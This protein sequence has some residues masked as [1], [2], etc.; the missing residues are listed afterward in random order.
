MR[1]FIVT[2]TFPPQIGGM[3]NVMF[4][5]AEKL[6]M[7][8]FSV[9]VLPKNELGFDAGFSVIHKQLPKFLRNGF[10]Y[11]Y[12]LKHLNDDDIVICD[13]WKSVVAVPPHKG[14]LVVLA[15]GQEYLKSGRRARRVQKALNRA[16]HLAVISHYTFG[17]VSKGWSIDHLKT[18]IIPPT[19]MLPDNA[20]KTAKRNNTPLQLVSICRLEARKGLLQSL[21]A[22][23]A[24]GDQLPDWRWQIG[25]GGAQHQELGEAIAQFGLD[26]KVTLLGRVDDA[27]KDAM[28]EAADLF[29]MPS[30]QHGKSLEGYGITYAEA[31]RFSVP[32]I[33]GIAGG[34]PEAVLDGETGWCVDTLDSAALQ[35]ALLTALTQ[36]DEREKRGAA[37]RTRYMK[38]LTGAAA[39][40]ALLKHIR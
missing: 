32:S 28:L 26:D 10:K 17:L 14:K 2:Q 38:Q 25:G 19:Y 5:L 39:F 24:L 21:Q 36:N 34:A 18:A 15:Y 16:T 7:S 12:L 37:A 4:S 6:H 40:S 8:D 23:A 29:V 13:S 30:Y 22:L 3:E 33:A 9:T 1:V 20:P 27:Q 35:A 11:R 31:A